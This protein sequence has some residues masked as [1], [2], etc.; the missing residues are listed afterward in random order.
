MLMLMGTL[1]FFY[2]ILKLYISY[3]EINF[4]SRAKSLPAI[5]LS[6]ENY[7]KAAEYKIA[8]ERFHIVSNLYDYALFL[9]WIM[10]GLKTLETLCIHEGGIIES[11][12]FVMSFIAINYLL[13]LPFDIYSTFVKDRK[14]GFSTISVKTY[15]LDNIKS[16]IIFI[17]LGTLVIA[18]VSWIISSFSL[19]WLWS[20]V[21]IFAIILFI[22]MFYPTFIAPI[23][24]KFTPLEDSELKNSIETLMQKAGLKSSGIFTMDA[25]KRDNRLNAY[26]GGLG[27]SKRVVLFDT[28]LKKLNKNELLAVL[29][30]EL[31]HFKHK[32]ILKNIAV[33]ATLLFVL[34]ALFGNLP[35]SV[36]EAL[37]LKHG[38]YSV[39]TIFLLF[40][41]AVSFVM[42]PLFGY[43]SRKN[44]YKADEYGSECESKEALAS[45][46]IKL[47][48]E[49][50][51]FP[52]SHFLY[53]IFYHTHP[54]L[55][56][57][58]K[59]LGV[60]TANNA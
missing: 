37:N 53:I 46:L 7:Q 52:R 32:D 23:F 27:K 34:F 44:E 24:N 31:G 25:S 4:V 40:S 43:L 1:Y 28:L 17:I 20:F 15:L 12:V 56:E 9:F 42:M 57:R 35:N 5:I 21:A 60:D 16:A 2:V 49:N 10:F 19:W 26:F 14:F 59:A 54:P 48:D 41:S 45:A 47:A 51:S 29:G 6:D 55:V 39:I 36:Y 50:K 11:T 33:T 13:S 18:L 58:L 38:A 22:N 30:H 3:S 8:N